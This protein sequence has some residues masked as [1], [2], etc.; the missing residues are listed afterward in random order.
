MAL[1]NVELAS[2]HL[3]SR[4]FFTKIARAIKNDGITKI[5]DC[6]KTREKP[7]GNRVISP[8]KFKRV[9]LYKLSVRGI[10][11][12]KMNNKAN[13]FNAIHKPAAANAISNKRCLLVALK[14][15]NNGIMVITKIQRFNS[16]NIKCKS[17]ARKYPIT[18]AINTDANNK[19]N[20]K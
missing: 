20:G 2:L 13:D 19:P 9:Q 12:E 18:A 5:C 10:S 4:N 14:V 11:W 6:K 17:L 7:F 8:S 15:I 16:S 1:E 3:A